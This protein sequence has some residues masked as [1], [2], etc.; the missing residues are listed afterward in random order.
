MVEA[1][2]V[3]KKKGK[4]SGRPRELGETTP[5]MLN[6]PTE[7]AKALEKRARSEARTKKAVMV[8]AL[9]RYLVEGGD[10]PP[11]PAST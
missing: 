10:W 7:L 8:R 11:P 4:K 5:F 1:T 3:A 2:L 9:E 6:L